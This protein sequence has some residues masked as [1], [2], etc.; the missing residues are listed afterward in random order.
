MTDNISSMAIYQASPCL[1]TIKSIFTSIFFGFSTITHTT[2]THS[3]YSVFTLIPHHHHT[4]PLSHYTNPHHHHT[5]APSLYSP[6]PPSFCNKTLMTG[7]EPLT[8]RRPMNPYV[9]RISATEGERIGPTY[10]PLSSYFKGRGKGFLPAVPN[11]T[12]HFFFIHLF[13]LVKGFGEINRALYHHK[14]NFYFQMM[15]IFSPRPV[16]KGK[17]D[18]LLVT[19][20]DFLWVL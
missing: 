18:K 6:S 15:I 3:Q 10:L 5:A 12:V 11:S 4:L 8:L 7:A 17:M 14:W 1:H 9:N 19:I 2:F 20:R 16:R 13:F